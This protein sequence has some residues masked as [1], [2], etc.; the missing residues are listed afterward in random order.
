MTS[1]IAGGTVLATY[2]ADPDYRQQ[3]AIGLAQAIGG[4]MASHRARREQE[5]ARERDE[6]TR[7]YQHALAD[8]E[9]AAAQGDWFVAK[10]G[11]KYPQLAPMVNLLKNRGGEAS[12]IRDAG[13][14]F[15]STQQQIEEKYR[16]DRE[17]LA[18]MPDEVAVD[19][20]IPSLTG[21]GAPMGSLTLPLP[22]AEKA[23]RGAQ[24]SRVQ[25]WAFQ[26]L[27]AQA[28]SPLD[29]QRARIAKAYTLDE[30]DA[31][32]DDVPV[33][34]RVL[35]A[36]A[37]DWLGAGSD[38]ALAGKVKNQLQQS[39]ATLQDQEYKTGERKAEETASLELEREKSKLIAGR[40][41]ASDARAM[42]RIERKAALNPQQRGGSGRGGGRGKAEA[43]LWRL[44][45][46]DSANRVKEWQDGLNATLTGLPKAPRAGLKE[47][48]ADITR[49]RIG[50]KNDY[51]RESG[52]R[53]AALSTA[54][55]ERIARKVAAMDLDADDAQLETAKMVEEFT[56]LTK[57]RGTTVEDAMR[58][59]L[60][61]EP[62]SMPAS[63]KAL[64]GGNGA[65][66][67]KA[68]EL[69]EAGKSWDEIE[70]LMRQ[71]GAG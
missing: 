33:E 65:A 69:R 62:A 66:A 27:A 55:A 15:L 20:P 59:V 45:L 44:A 71:A 9:L 43:P 13:K 1:P 21:S 19:V 3:K 14:R 17:A 30:F 61:R 32:G 31:F 49:M 58:I 40:D 7:F 10:Y 67:A 23:V 50:A 11:K 47:T 29:R 48:Q 2:S 8:S 57:V 46:D 63:V 64:V 37:L 51:L 6:I 42:E 36:D 22:N 5:E 39:P 70:R 28:M 12:A 53:P 60:S 41:E 16:R 38:M 35:F 68:S 52:G 56:K 25:P 24:L 34:Q 26:H 18:G 54:N 4:A